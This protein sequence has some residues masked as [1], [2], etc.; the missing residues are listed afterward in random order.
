MGDLSTKHMQIN[1]REIESQQDH[2]YLNLND[3]YFDSLRVMVCATSVVMFC[4]C[5]WLQAGIL[6]FILKLQSF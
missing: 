6:F 4:A 2:F 5:A 3:V 1:T